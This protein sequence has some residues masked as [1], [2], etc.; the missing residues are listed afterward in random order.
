M[1]KFIANS[2]CQFMPPWWAKNKH[3]QT[4]LPVLTKPKS[5]QLTRHRLELADGDFI[6][7]DISQNNSQAKAILLIVHGLEG[8]AQSHYA[9]RMIHQCLQHDVLAIVHHHRGCSGESN[10]LARAYHSGEIEDLTNSVNVIHQQ[11]PDLPLF[12]IGYSLGGN[13]LTKYLVHT[14]QTPI[15]RAAMIS[16]PFQLSCSA[17]RLEQGFSKVYQQYLLKQ[18]KQKVRV[19]LTQ[20]AIAPDLAKLAQ[21]LEKFHRFYDFDE[22]ITA[23]LHGFKNAQ[24]Y[25]QQSSTVQQLGQ[26]PIPSLILHAED[27]PFMDESVIPNQDSLPDFIHYELHSHGGHVG[28]INGGTPWR[29]QYYLE[30]RVIDF[31]LE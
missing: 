1:S 28:F 8:S 23:P 19:K 13:M 14:P 18:L 12:A 4:I 9:R 24:D 2:S 17:K 22:H 16:A 5:A 20:E 25:Y 29:P 21:D 15:Q 10:R 30:Q 31:L 11:Y 6:D 7:L 27:D 3:L 26:L